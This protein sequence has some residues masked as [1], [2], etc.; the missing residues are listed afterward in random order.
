MNDLLYVSLSVYVAYALMYAILHKDIMLRN[1]KNLLG[2]SREELG[3][4]IVEN[5]RNVVSEAIKE[6]ILHPSKETDGRATEAFERLRRIEKDDGF[7]DILIDEYTESFKIM[8]IMRRV[9]KFFWVLIRDL[10]TLI[11]I[12]VLL[13]T[14]SLHLSILVSGVMML[15]F[16]LFEEYMIRLALDEIYDKDTSNMV[17]SSISAKANIVLTAILRQSH[18]YL[19]LLILLYK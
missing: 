9:K 15:L 2:T 18:F 12:L 10:Y 17:M 7:I 19:T 3:E 13:I 1:I 8:L 5:E 6:D 11:P 14:W 4:F 16:S